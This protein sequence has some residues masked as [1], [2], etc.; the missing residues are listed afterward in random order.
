MAQPRLRDRRDLE[1]GL[2]T[3]RKVNAGH[4][5]SPEK[6]NERALRDG[7]ASRSFEADLER[8]LGFDRELHRQLEDLEAIDDEADGVFGV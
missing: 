8:L 4:R 1:K 2:P 6:R 7:P 3:G 5:G